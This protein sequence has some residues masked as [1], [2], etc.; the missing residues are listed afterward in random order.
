MKCNQKAKLSNDNNAMLQFL[1]T[2][3][4]TIILLYAIMYIGTYT[5]G[6]IGSQL[7]DTMG[8]NNETGDKNWRNLFQNSTVNTLENMSGDFDSNTEIIS[9]AAI[10]TILTVPLIAIASVRRLF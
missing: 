1:P 8:N 5:N 3:G 2:I 6:T 10:V 9:V 4:F 7:I